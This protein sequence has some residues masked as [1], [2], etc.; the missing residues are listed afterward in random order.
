MIVVSVLPNDIIFSIL[1][2]LP[3]KSLTRFKTVSKSWNALITDSY[4]IRQHYSLLAQRQISSKLLLVERVVRGSTH[5]Y[6]TRLTFDK[7]SKNLLAHRNMYKPYKPY[8][9]NGLD[10]L[11]CILGPCFGVF[12]FGVYPNLEGTMRFTLCNIATG[13]KKTIR[14]LSCKKNDRVVSCAF[15]FGCVDTTVN[16][17]EFKIV[18]LSYLSTEDGDG[19]LKCVSHVYTFATDSWKI[20]EPCQSFTEEVAT[21]VDGIIYWLAKTPEEE[22]RLDK[23]NSF[24]V[25]FDLKKE[26]FGRIELPHGIHYRS[27]LTKQDDKYLSLITHSNP[28]GGVINIWV[29]HGESWVMQARLGP[30]RID[31][32]MMLGYWHS[33]GGMLWDKDTG[34]VLIIGDNC[35]KCCSKISFTFG[36][37]LDYVESLVS[38]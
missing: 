9:S 24:I 22:K 12:C 34:I 16:V 1:L 23:N 31:S 28:S 21:E 32:G 15:G 5:I 7:T 26:V 36:L 17:L 18:R 2:R 37:L 11:R 38:F 4:F 27:T 3:V 14:T 35:Y 6:P 25:T 33:T 13:E 10:S 30:S 20:T 19:L 8:L 29:M